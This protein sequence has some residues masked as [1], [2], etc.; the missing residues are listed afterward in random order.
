MHGVVV[1]AA[2]TIYIGVE[3]GA[4]LAEKYLRRR[5]REGREEGL[6]EG[7]REGVR[8][9]RKEVEAAWSAWHERMLDAQRRG[10][11]FDEPP[12]KMEDTPA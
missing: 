2:A 5:Y 7:R 1:V 3:G 9:G 6:E 4:M 12:P 10:E 11:P 8:E